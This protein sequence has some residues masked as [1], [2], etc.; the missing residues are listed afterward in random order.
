MTIV[1]NGF[2]GRRNTAQEMCGLFFPGGRPVFGEGECSAEIFVAAEENKCKEKTLYNVTVS[3]ADGSV[4]CTASDGARSDDKKGCDIAIRRAFFRAASEMTGL[5]PPWGVLTGIR[6]AKLVRML[7]AG[8]MTAEQAADALEREY[9]VSPKKSRLAAEVWKNEDRVMKRI[10]PAGTAVY[11][12]IPFCPSRCSYCTFVSHSID[13]AGRLLEPYLELLFYD[14]E[15]KGGILKDAGVK[16]S[17]VYI[18]GGTPTTLNEAQLSALL[19]AA[20]KSFDLSGI[21]EYTVECG[22]PDTLTR[23]KLEMLRSFGVDRVS[24]NPQ[25]MQDRTLEL[26]GR[27]HSTAQTLTAFETAR[28]VGFKCINTDLIAGL[29]GETVSDFDDTLERILALSPENVTVHTLSL[30]KGSYLTNAGGRDPRDGTVEKMVDLSCERLSAEGYLPY[31]LYRQKNIRDNLENTGWCRPGLEG[32]YNISV[33][34]EVTSITACGAGAVTKLYD[35]ANDRIERIFN[36][37]Y[38]YEYIDRSEKLKRDNRAVRD[39]FIGLN[40][41]GEYENRA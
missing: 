11:I 27:R 18:G 22:R 28:D 21:G 40:G 16:I 23:K 6:P 8:G 9:L 35:R 1:L 36:L 14:M 7:T 39:F 15:Q 24:I 17:S 2:E 38:P 3:D 33:M 25:T 19:A 34:E 20:E 32:L 29:P 13:K 26:I 30:K 4:R 12:A 10:S 31:Y 5:N 41:G 37:K